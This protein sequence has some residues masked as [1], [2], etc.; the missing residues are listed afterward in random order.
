MHFNNSSPLSRHFVRPIRRVLT[1]VDC[2][3][4]MLQLMLRFNAYK[5]HL[6]LDIGVHAANSPPAAS[7]NLGDPARALQL[8]GPASN[9]RDNS[10]PH[11][12]RGTGPRGGG[13]WVATRW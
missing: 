4:A 3:L 8:Q 7:M 10:R 13:H 11:L 9:H 5:V 2:A 6:T 12:R 1:A